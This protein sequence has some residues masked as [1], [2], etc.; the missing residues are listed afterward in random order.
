MV[1]LS[2]KK[3]ESSFLG[4]SSFVY[5]CDTYL[6]FTITS[7][8]LGKLWHTWKSW[9][10]I[11]LI[12]SYL[13]L[14]SKWELFFMYGKLVANT[15]I[16]CLTCSGRS[17]IYITHLYRGSS[18]NLSFFFFYFWMAKPITSVLQKKPHGK[19]LFCIVVFATLLFSRAM[20]KS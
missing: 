10:V 4:K 15:H 14:M 1:F 13:A 19:A 17:L 5:P 6:V 12:L 11:R 16:A 18:V 2:Y 3:H 20:T 8:K 7:M 9:T